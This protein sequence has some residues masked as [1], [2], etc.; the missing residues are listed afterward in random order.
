M[1]YYRLVRPALFALPPE[2]A[3]GLSLWALRLGLAPRCAPVGDPILAQKLFGL[4][5]AN[6]VGLAAGYDKNA[7]ATVALPGLGFGF[8][9]VG[10]VTPRAQ[11]GN[12]RPRLFRLAG[13]GAIINRLGFNNAGQTAMRQRLENRTGGRRGG[14]IGVNIGANRDSADPISDY[15]AGFTAMAPVADYIAV[16]ISSPNTPGLRDL[17]ARAKIGELLARLSQARAEAPDAAKTPILIKIAP[18]LERQALA[19]IVEAAVDTGM[20]GLIVANTTTARPGLEGKAARQAGGL[21]GRPLFAPSTAML[22]Q[23]YL[24][25]KGRLPLIGVGGISSGADA[26]TKIKAGA[27]LVQL[28]TGL[29]YEGPGLVG[30]ILGELASGLRRQGFDSLQAAVGVEADELARGFAKK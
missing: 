25:A 7:V 18:D 14:I 22:A 15:V 30:R 17:Q 20:D 13:D 19:D 28:Y 29:V 8:V 4:D 3:H 5:F 26:L 24:L 27:S 1:D 6:P 16:N 23:T 2:G 11:K 12:P 10:T 9:E 21:S